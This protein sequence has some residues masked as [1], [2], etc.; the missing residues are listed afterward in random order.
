MHVIKMKIF[1]IVMLQCGMSWFY[2]SLLAAEDASSEP[3]KKIQKAAER[4]SKRMKSLEDKL[5]EDVKK[6]KAALIKVVQR[7]L[8]DAERS[9]DDHEATRLQTKLTV[10]QGLSK[11]G[12]FG[13]QK[14]E[15]E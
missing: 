13:E 7:E 11:V 4:Y 1:I 14:K 5:E 6:A 12:L 15:S 3:D 9:G 2:P 10:L 8:D